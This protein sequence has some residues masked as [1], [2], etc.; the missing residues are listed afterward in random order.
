MYV[1]FVLRKLD[2]FRKNHAEFKNIN[3]LITLYYTLMMYILEFGSV[4]WNPT[5]SGQIDKFK[6]LKICFIHMFD[7]RISSNDNLLAKLV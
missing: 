6:K 1:Y 5:Q 4:N 3:Y 7:Y 2:F